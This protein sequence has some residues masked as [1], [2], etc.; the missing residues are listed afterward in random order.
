MKYKICNYVFLLAFNHL[1]KNYC[2]F[3]QNESFISTEG[4]SPPC[5]A[6]VVLTK[7]ALFAVIS[8]YHSGG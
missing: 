8:S 4:V 3:S 2:V 7:H 6:T 5:C 1:K